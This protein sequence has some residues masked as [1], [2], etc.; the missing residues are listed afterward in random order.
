MQSIFMK[1]TVG[2]K[3]IKLSRGVEAKKLF[4]GKRTSKAI[5]LDDLI[6]LIEN[7]ASDLMDFC[8]VKIFIPKIQQIH[9]KNPALLKNIDIKI[10]IMITYNLSYDYKY[11]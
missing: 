5:K 1:W 4:N 6:N 7:L 2:T 8:E 9:W 11:E 3:L 10:R